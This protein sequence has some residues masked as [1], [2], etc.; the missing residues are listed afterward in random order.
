[1]AKA[2][3]RKIVQGVYLRLADGGIS[4]ASRSS[5]EQHKTWKVV[6]KSFCVK[7]IVVH[8]KIIPFQ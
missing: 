7:K 2:G 1:M 3:H 5:V 6:T 8:L 4:K